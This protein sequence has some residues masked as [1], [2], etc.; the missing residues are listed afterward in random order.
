[1][2]RIEVM[3]F[4]NELQGLKRRG[5]EQSYT[6]DEQTLHIIQVFSPASSLIHNLRIRNDIV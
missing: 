6:S 5:E 3:S 2:N 1:M 4:S